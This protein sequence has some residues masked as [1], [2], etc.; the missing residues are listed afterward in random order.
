MMAGSIFIDTN[1]LVYANNALSPLCDASR[2]KL[3]ELAVNYKNLWLSRQ[4]LREFASVVSREMVIAKQPDFE[5]L[6]RVIR[7]FE[8]DFLIAEDAAI[9]T[10]LWLQLLKETQSA[11]K[12]VH[13]T[14]IV[15]TMLVNNI[16]TLLTHNVSDFNRFSHLITVLPLV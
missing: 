9:V 2:R 11:G 13:D 5:N 1:I 4:V 14:N 3:N 7:Q 8:S 12:Q 16:D 6:E 15:A 10:D